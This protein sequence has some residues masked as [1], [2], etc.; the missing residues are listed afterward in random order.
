MPALKEKKR[1]I[2]IATDLSA[3]DAE[4][5][6]MRCVHDYIGLL[7]AA[8]AGVQFLSECWDTTKGMGIIRCNNRYATEIKASLILSKNRFSTPFTTGIIQKAKT[9][10]KRYDGN[11]V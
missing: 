4:K 10:I 5:E 6:I 3:G 8:R 9:F 2:V 1:Y 7:G 11:K